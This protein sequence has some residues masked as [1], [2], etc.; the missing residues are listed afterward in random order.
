M[1]RLTWEAFNGI[2]LCIAADWALAGVEG[3]A[4]VWTA[5]AFRVNRRANRIASAV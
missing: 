2:G 3:V 5:R 4:Q 1:F